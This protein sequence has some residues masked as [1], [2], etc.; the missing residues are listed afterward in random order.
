VSVGA[1]LCFERPDVTEKWKE[2]FDA[3]YVEAGSG[4]NREIIK[5][6]ADYESVDV[7]LAYICD[8]L[9]VAQPATT[10]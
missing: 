7:P 4:K 10:S 1:K 9:G 3:S 5:V 6:M 8:R 2:E